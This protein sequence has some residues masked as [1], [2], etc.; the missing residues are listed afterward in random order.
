MIYL[1][2]LSQLPIILILSYVYARDT[3]EREPLKLLFLCFLG[4]IFAFAPAVL[5][6]LLFQWLM[7]QGDARTF[8]V[9]SI[10]MFLGIALVEEGCKLIVLLLLVYGSG[11]FNEPFDGIIYAVAVS[12]GMAAFENALY[13]LQH[14]IAIAWLRMFTAVPMHAMCAI[15][16]GFYLGQAKFE[17]NRKSRS[18]IVLGLI[19]ATVAHGSYD[20]FVSLGTNA[21][22]PLAVFILIVQVILSMR[23]MRIHNLH[24]AV[25]GSSTCV[26]FPEHERSLIT[27]PIDVSVIALN[28][29]AGLT[30][31]WAVVNLYPPLRTMLEIPLEIA[32]PAGWTGL[33]TAIISMAASRGLRLKRSAAWKLS[34]GIF[35]ILLPTPAFV[36]S[37]AGLFGLLHPDS[38]QVF[39][40]ITENPKVS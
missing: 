37:L 33:A 1:L 31:L 9:H 14:G 23:A 20:Y 19:A 26:Y 5:L 4:G 35:V 32:Y 21:Y 18:L 11:E 8:L 17:R 30:L 29:M 34:L 22:V 10:E 27:V 38:R 36:I 25:H 39:S 16:M 40:A 7:P 24:P 3:H 13:S 6:E 12:L 15:L 28:L 2:G